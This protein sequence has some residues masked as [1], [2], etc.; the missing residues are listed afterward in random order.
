MLLFPLYLDHLN[1]S[2]KQIGLVMASSSIGGLLFRPVVGW[3]LDTWGRRP[4]LA[5]GTVVL[6]LG[7]FLIWPVDTIGPS[8]YLQRVVYGAGVGA[9]FT[10]YFTFAADIVPESR[11]TEGIA[12]FGISGLT[13]LAV[14]PIAESVGVSGA[15]LQWFLPAMG[16]VILLSLVPLFFVSEPRR[17]ATKERLQF[18]AV[19]TALRKPELLPTW[20][21]TLVFAGMVELFFVFASVTAESRN[22]PNPARFWLTYAIGAVFVRLVG[23]RI[24]DKLGPAN[25]IAPAMA[26]EVAAA[27]VLAGAESEQGLLW[28]GLLAGFGHGYCFPVLT[29]QVISRSPEHLRGSAMSM[30]TSL[31]EV[32]VLFLP[33]IFGIIADATNHAMLFSSGALACVAGLVIWAVMEHLLAPKTSAQHAL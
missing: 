12:L 18:K 8:A 32:T 27:L 19:L 23:A 10:G 15:H 30:F 1:A 7:M 9:L 5:V 16:F 14:G 6:A 33:P 20:M 11:R 26:I 24:P 25:F 2:G 22:I 3:A 13:P 17:A 28:S 21:A 29:S 4:T 31:W